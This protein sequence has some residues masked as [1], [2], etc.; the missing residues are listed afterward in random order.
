M[1]Q[2]SDPTRGEMARTRVRKPPQ[3]SAPEHAEMG[4][5]DSTQPLSTQK[6]IDSE[7]NHHAGPS[8]LTP[9]GVFGL[10]PSAESENLPTTFVA[11]PA[12][13][14]GGR[15]KSVVFTEHLKIE[16]CALISVGL[17]LAQ[18]AGYLGMAR[19]TLAAALAHDTDFADGVQNARE[20]AQGQLLLQLA[21]ASK[22][23]WKAAVYL[24]EHLE[25]R[26]QKVR[27]RKESATVARNT[28]KLFPEL[29]G[30]GPKTPNDETANVTYESPRKRRKK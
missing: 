21:Q 13:R 4:S 23:S 17:T 30:D 5:Q 10:D 26:P 16:A 19:S 11:M 9:E 20:M 6:L 12:P 15:P 3:Q 28:R 18:T 29:Y 8:G 2:L 14:L 22:T 24:L 1:Y 25:Q 27:S 7:P